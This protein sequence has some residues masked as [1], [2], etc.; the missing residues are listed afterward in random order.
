MEVDHLEPGH[1]VRVIPV[2][3]NFN[4]LGKALWNMGM[5]ALLPSDSSFHEFSMGGWMLPTSHSGKANRNIVSWGVRWIITDAQ[6]REFFKENPSG[7][8]LEG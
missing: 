2:N 8:Y 4:S 3:L 6:S 7:M 5:V 1:P